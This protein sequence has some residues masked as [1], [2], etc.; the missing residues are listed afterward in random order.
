MHHITKFH[1]TDQARNFYP[2]L[3]PA[4]DDSKHRYESEIREAFENGCVGCLGEVQE[5]QELKV[6]AFPSGHRLSIILM[7][8]SQ[9]NAKNVKIVFEVRR[10]YTRE[11]GEC[12]IL[13]RDKQQNRVIVNE[14]AF[15][16]GL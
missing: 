9:P 6:T 3:D 15:G 1:V 11:T 8:L 13:V 10:C 12:G 2:T 7:P 14:S 16:Q 5:D 4:L